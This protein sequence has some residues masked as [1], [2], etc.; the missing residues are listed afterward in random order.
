MAERPGSANC[1]LPV[2][3]MMMR[4]AKLWGYR[5]YNTNPCKNARRYRM[6]PKERSLNAG[7]MARFNAVLTS[8]EF[9]CPR[10]SP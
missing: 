8:D 6:E 2:L 7:E 9:Y 4:M 10:P 3:S 5:P 1:T